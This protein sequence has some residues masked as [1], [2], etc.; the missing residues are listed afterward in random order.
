M[1]RIRPEQPGDNSAI[2]NVV[3]EAFEGR[4]DEPDLVDLIRDHGKTIVSFVA[5]QEGQVIGHIL[6]T[7]IELDPNPGLNC[8]AIAPLSVLPSYQKEGIGS[9]L[10]NEAIA[11]CKQNGFDVVF[12]LGHPDYYPRFGFAA[13]HIGNEYGAT[14]AFMALE[15]R[16]GVLSAIEGTARYIPEFNEIGV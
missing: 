3:L 13:T 12:L 14:D 16:P 15:L 1:I 9:S 7:R 8:L 6:L 4:S 2:H 5:E 11:W 10:M